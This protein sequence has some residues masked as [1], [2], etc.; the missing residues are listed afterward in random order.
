MDRHRLHRSDPQGDDR[1]PHVGRGLRSP[2]ASARLGC[3]TVGQWM[4]GGKKGISGRGRRVGVVLIAAG[5]L[6]LGVVAP[7]ALGAD[8]IYW[9]NGGTDTISYANLDG[10]GGGGELNLSGATPSGPRGVAIDA[11]AGRI[12]WANQGNNTI[13]YANLDGTG[14]GG[15]LNISGTLTNKPHGL[16]ID[17]PA[18]RIY[19]V[20]DDNTVSYAQP[21][22]LGRRAAGHHRRDPRRALRRGDRS[23]GREDL[24]GQPRHQHDL[25]RQPRRLRRRRRAQ[26]LRGD[27]GGPT[28]RGDRSR[29]R[30]DLLG[31]RQCTGLSHH[32]LLRQPRWIGRRRRAQP[33]RRTERT[34]SASASTPRPEGS[35]WGNLGNDNL[36]YV[37]LDDLGG[38]GLFNALPG[39]PERPSLRGDASR[40]EPHR[41]AADHGRLEPERRPQLLAGRVGA[42]RCSAS[43][44]YRAPQSFVYQWTRDGTEING[45]TET[46]YTASAMATT[47]AV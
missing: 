5:L 29:V 40:A 33:L 28:W 8:R 25:L 19:W 12:Y 38:G 14:G 30:K 23:S 21:R 2:P 13:S 3:R 27:A 26:P 4:P 35:T 36:S 24:L 7:A 6:A 45:A 42:R 41:S 15:Q 46:S 1:G 16:A 17:P 20:N 39:D 44:F 9:G 32:D 47:A 34:S 10:T 31:Q 43:F 18:E 11:A 22:R 37:N